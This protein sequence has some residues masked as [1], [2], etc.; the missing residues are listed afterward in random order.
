MSTRAT[1]NFANAIQ[2]F[3]SAKIT[4]SV[5]IVKQKSNDIDG[6]FIVRKKYSPETG[7]EVGEVREKIDVELLERKKT[8]LEHDLQKITETLA[9]INSIKTK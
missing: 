8:Q 5:R 3:K 1:L 2:E 6:V 7:E 4:G 9:E